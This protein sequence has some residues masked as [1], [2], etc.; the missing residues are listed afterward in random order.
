MPST[1]TQDTRVLEAVEG[2]VGGEVSGQRCYWT[3]EEG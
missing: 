3:G 1:E 2:E